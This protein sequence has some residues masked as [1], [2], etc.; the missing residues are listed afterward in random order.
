[1]PEALSPTDGMTRAQVTL[2]WCLVLIVALLALSPLLHSTFFVVSFDDDAFI[3]D[4][5]HIRSFSWQAVQAWFGSFYHADYVP[6]TL[7]SFALDYHVWGLRPAGYHLT[8]ILLHLIASSLVAIFAART[9][10][11]R[12]VGVLAGALFALHPLQLETVAI[13]SQRKTILATIFALFALIAYQG[14]LRRSSRRSYLASLACFAIGGLAKSSIVP[15]PFLLALC[16]WLDRRR[17]RIPDKIPFLAVA[18]ALTW[19]S[20]ASKLGVGVIKAP[21]GGSHVVTALL[22][23]RV[24][25]EYLAAFF[26][27][28][29]LSAAYY[30]SPALAYSPWH[31]AALA[32]VVVVHVGLWLERERFPMTAFGLFWFTLAMLPVSNIIP[33]AVVR[34]D[35]YMYLGMIGLVSWAAYG[36]ARLP[37]PSR[38]LRTLR[39]FAFYALLLPLGAAT[40]AATVNWRNDVTIWHRV[41]IEHPWNARAHYLLGKAYV[42]VG[43]FADALPVLDTATKEDPKYA[44][45]HVLLAYVFLRMGNPERARS[46]VRRGIALDPLEPLPESL[47]WLL[48]SPSDG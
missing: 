21:P 28:I 42:N 35:R 19:L 36:L 46:E 5:P 25:V 20:I 30:Y 22:M 37:S 4:N 38:S 48:E 18:A 2:A 23:G 33:I 45:P 8:N 27:P 15:L 43:D 11:R 47:R 12:D 39:P 34:A 7:A 24:W 13:I 16:E 9:S 17:I 6:V 10:R 1:V 40:M 29:H 3:L 44:S 31:A 32:L 41:V 26:V 14:Y